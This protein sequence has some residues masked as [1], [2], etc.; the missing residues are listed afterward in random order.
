MFSVEIFEIKIM[1]VHAHILQST[2][3]RLPG[4]A[5]MMPTY[6]ELAIVLFTAKRHLKE[7]RYR[8]YHFGARRCYVNTVCVDEELIQSNIQHQDKE[9]QGQEVPS[10]SR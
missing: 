8:G 3:P 1:S 10:F 4:L 7:D 6:G 9:G 5:V 2:S